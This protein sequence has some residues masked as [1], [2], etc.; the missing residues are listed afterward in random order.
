MN[1]EKKPALSLADCLKYAD[2][3]RELVLKNDALAE[4]PGLLAKHFNFDSVCLV[5]D[6]NTLKAAGQR[7]KERL[8]EAGIKIA[9]IHVFPYSRRTGTAAAAMPQLPDNVVT[10]RANDLRARTKK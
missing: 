4:I 1:Q 2:E 10:R 3:T 5:A 8:G 6:D 9:G 7:A